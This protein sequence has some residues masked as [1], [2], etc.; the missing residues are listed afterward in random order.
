MRNCVETRCYTLIRN[1]KPAES[2]MR[3][4]A[5]Q[6]V[7]GN[8]LGLAILKIQCVSPVFSTRFQCEFDMYKN[9]SGSVMCMLVFC[10]SFSLYRGSAMCDCVIS[11]SHSRTFL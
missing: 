1:D 6:R 2:K 4:A 9:A 10:V 7:I 8:E 5:V 3:Y 11:W